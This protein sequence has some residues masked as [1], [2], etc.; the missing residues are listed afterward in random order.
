MSKSNNSTRSPKHQA[1]IVDIYKK[2]VPYTM[3]RGKATAALNE[4]NSCP[5]KST[6]EY[7][8]SF[9]VEPNS[10]TVSSNEAKAKSAIRNKLSKLDVD[11]RHELVTGFIVDK[12]IPYLDENP[13]VVLTWSRNK[14]TIARMFENDLIDQ[15]RHATTNQS[16]F[17]SS[18]EMLDQA[19]WNLIN[20]T[21]TTAED[22][23]NVDFDQLHEC[24][25]TFRASLGPADRMVFSCAM[26]PESDLNR[27]AFVAQ[28]L[29]QLGVSRATFYR[30]LADLKLR[31]AYYR[32]S[33][34]IAEGI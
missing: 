24:Y 1:L 27:N 17:E 5:W 2:L 16:R 10:L 7:M 29:A 13:D 20:D 14:G 33:L 25:E 23:M 34:K 3:N 28:C 21:V 32:R 11:G 31:A 9:T 4:A 22:T 18:I 19:D 6:K 26:I 30:R 15:H 8:A 12:M